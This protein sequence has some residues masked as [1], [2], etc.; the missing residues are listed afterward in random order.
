MRLDRVLVAVLQCVRQDAHRRTQ[1]DDLRCFCIRQADIQLALLVLLQHLLLAIVVLL[2][3]LL[4]WLKLLL[5]VRLVCLW[6]EQY[7]VRLLIGE[8]CA[9]VRLLYRLFI[10]IGCLLLADLK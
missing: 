9:A 4:L 8:V 3:M 10:F 2:L 6:L 7:V 1:L 5:R